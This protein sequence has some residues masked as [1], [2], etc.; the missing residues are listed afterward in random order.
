ML[1]PLLSLLN[2]PVLINLFY[3]L[4]ETLVVPLKDQALL[5]FRLLKKHLEL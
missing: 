1:F 4:C 2:F 3:R 5:H